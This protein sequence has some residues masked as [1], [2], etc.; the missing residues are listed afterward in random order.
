[1]KPR[2][3]VLT[4]TYPLWKG[5]SEPG[6]VHELSRRLVEDFE[7]HVLAPHAPG[8][9]LCEL[10]DAVRVE[11]FRYAPDRFEQLAYRG[12]ISERIREKRWRLLLVPLLLVSQ[13]ICTWLIVRRVKPAVIHAHW[14]FPQAFIAALVNLATSKPV[15]IICTVH[16]ADWYQLKG[17]FWT[18]IKRWTLKR[19]FRVAPVSGILSDALHELDWGLRIAEEPMPMGVHLPTSPPLE[20]PPEKH[21]LLFVGRLVPKKGL[22]V[23]LDALAILKQYDANVRLKVVGG[24]PEQERYQVKLTELGL[25][26]M[27]T[28]VGPVKHDDVYR[29]MSESR[30]CI[31][32]SVEAIDGD[33]EGLG[34]VFL[35]ALVCGCRVI[36]SD[37]AVFK[38]LNGSLN[39]PAQLFS[40]GDPGALAAAIRRECGR[41]RQSGSYTSGA[42]SRVT[43]YSWPVAAERYKLL[44]QKIV[45]AAAST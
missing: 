8:A 11:R 33:Q 2:L 36:A 45:T 1:M 32:P 13:V 23:L 34:L 31:V 41:K 42:G 3:L 7:V 21:G 43:M 29:L 15:P 26:E 17:G 27:V 4:S 16:G 12:G 44:M 5:D 22:D 10:L 20:Q 40:A 25:E 39:E 14:I 24:G 30:I 37:I 6:F 9:E 28:L 19:C 38:E 18:A 35:E